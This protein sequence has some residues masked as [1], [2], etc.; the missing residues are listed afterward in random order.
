MILLVD[1]YDS[2]TYNLYQYLAELYDG[3]IIVKRNDEVTLEDAKTASH[4][5]ISPGPGH[6]AKDE[7]FGMN[8]RILREVSPHVPTLGVCLGHQGIGITYGGEVSAAKRIMHGK[9]SHIVHTERGIFRGIPQNITVARYHSFAITRIPQDLEVEATTKD[10]EIM[11]IRHRSY[12]IY[13]VQFHPESV[14]SEYGHEIIENFL[15][16]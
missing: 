4:I 9:V 7:D 10:G 15:A 11:A 2:F 1:N 6:P 3:E 12:P 8:S 13:G 14:L 16:L 5:V